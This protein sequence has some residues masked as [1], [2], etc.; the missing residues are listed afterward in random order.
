MQ[1]SNSL[2]P[3]AVSRPEK[4]E[5]SPVTFVINIWALGV[6]LQKLY[7]LILIVPRQ[8]KDIFGKLNLPFFN[9]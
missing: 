6:R 7:V 9:F 2:E 8:Q 3:L 4:M 5:M 1:K